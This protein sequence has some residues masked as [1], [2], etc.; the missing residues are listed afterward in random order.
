MGAM[1]V[2][3]PRRPGHRTFLQSKVF[4]L[5]IEHSSTKT[6]PLNL[7]VHFRNMFIFVI[8]LYK[9]FTVSGH[10]IDYKELSQY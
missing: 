10:F 7:C 4:Y 6:I 3:S 8:I 5:L 1:S 2:W 9:Y